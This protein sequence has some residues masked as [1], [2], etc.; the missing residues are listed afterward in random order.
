MR[1]LDALDYEEFVD[2]L[3]TV[4]AVAETMQTTVP[5]LSD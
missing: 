3:E 2:L 1:P 5:E 4:A